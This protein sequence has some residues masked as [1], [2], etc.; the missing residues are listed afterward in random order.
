MFGEKFSVEIKGKQ[1]ETIR[2]DITRKYNGYTGLYGVGENGYGDF[3]NVFFL[4]AYT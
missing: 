4:L 3:K 2:H 1:N